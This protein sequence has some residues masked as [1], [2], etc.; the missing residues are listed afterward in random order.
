MFDPTLET[1]VLH[2]PPHASWCIIHGHVLLEWSDSAAYKAIGRNG[3]RGTSLPICS[4]L[5]GPA[6]TAYGGPSQIICE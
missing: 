3:L 1:P 2:Y 6:G 5:S 4:W